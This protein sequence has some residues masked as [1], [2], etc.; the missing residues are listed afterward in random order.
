MRE[1]VQPH[2]K[3]LG[4]KDLID[5]APLPPLVASLKERSKQEVEAMLKKKNKMRAAAEESKD[6][7]RR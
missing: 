3:P 5:F 1:R 2:P 7:G 4:G 6:G